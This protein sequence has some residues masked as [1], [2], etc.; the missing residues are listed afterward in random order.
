MLRLP[1]RRFGVDELGI[2]RL[3]GFGLDLVAAP[4][5]VDFGMPNRP[6]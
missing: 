3:G 1:N 6:L 4:V 5:Q 2:S